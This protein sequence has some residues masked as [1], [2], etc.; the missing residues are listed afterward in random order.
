MNTYRY[1]DVDHKMAIDARGNVKITYDTDAIIQS[2][3]MLIGSFV[4]EYVRSPR[5]SRVIEYIGQPMTEVTVENL[6]DEIVNMISL[7]ERRVQIIQIVVNPNYDENYYDTR[8]VMRQ[9]EDNQPISF[10][11]RLRSLA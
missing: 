1:S 8:I 9:I 11:T 5:G 7:Y 6:R 4:G 2:I 10:S 3:K